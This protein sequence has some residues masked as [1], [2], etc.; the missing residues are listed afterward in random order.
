MPQ[1]ASLVKDLLYL[2]I[3]VIIRININYV[4]QVP[5]EYDSFVVH[6]F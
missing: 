4:L 1:S 6:Q 2:G 3:T 5:D